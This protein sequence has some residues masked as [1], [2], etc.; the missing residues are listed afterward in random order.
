MESNQVADMA[1][2]DASYIWLSRN[3]HPEKIKIHKI[4]FEM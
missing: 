4:S 3:Y 1:K 2:L